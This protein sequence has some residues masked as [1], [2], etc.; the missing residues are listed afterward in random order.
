MWIRTRKNE[1]SASNQNTESQE[2]ARNN[3]DL[4]QKI[5]SEHTRQNLSDGTPH[6][7]SIQK[8]IRVFRKNRETEN[9][10]TCHLLV[11]RSRPRGAR[12]ETDHLNIFLNS[13]FYAIVKTMCFPVP[14]CPG[15]PRIS[16][17]IPP[18]FPSGFPQ[19]FPKDSRRI[20]P[21]IPPGILQEFPQDSP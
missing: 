3:R 10:R 15:F 17:R 20:S 5:L 4:T 18:G 6:Q 2:L 16:R 14:R 11:T 1:V 12:P 9:T 8:D 21:R 7:P 19:D 13:R